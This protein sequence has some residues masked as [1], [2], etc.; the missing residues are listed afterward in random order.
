[1][2]LVI[3]LFLFF[4]FRFI[5]GV[6]SDYSVLFCKSEFTVL[7]FFRICVHTTSDEFSNIEKIG[8]EHRV[9]RSRMEIFE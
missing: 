9:E 1:M 7:C 4:R 5:V 3:T 6:S 8:L 2:F